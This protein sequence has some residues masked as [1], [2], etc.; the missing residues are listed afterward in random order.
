LILSYLAHQNLVI[1]ASSA[2]S[3]K[4]FIGA[5]H[6]A[7]KD[8]NHLKDNA[9][10]STFIYYEAIRKQIIYKINHMGHTHIGLWVNQSSLSSGVTHFQHWPTSAY[11]LL[12][13]KKTKYNVC[14][15]VSIHSYIYAFIYPCILEY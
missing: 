7:Q 14:V 3:E 13:W 6:I 4:H 9:V 8:R 11:S 15:C 2:E 5:G 12:L 10:E 1:P